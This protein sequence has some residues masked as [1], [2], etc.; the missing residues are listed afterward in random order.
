MV[1]DEIFF[2]S[3]LCKTQLVR[4]FQD[5]SLLLALCARMLR[6]H[7]IK[8]HAT[9]DM[10]HKSLGFE[11]VHFMLYGRVWLQQGVLVEQSLQQGYGCCCR[12]T[13]GDSQ[14]PGGSTS[15]HDEVADST[16]D[17]CPRKT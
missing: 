17:A 14:N 7:R 10:M 16:A 4:R 1:S 3:D 15:V 6:S 11:V 8:V 12:L 13:G 2:R 5:N 9:A